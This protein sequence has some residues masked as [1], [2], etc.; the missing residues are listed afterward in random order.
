MS[1]DSRLARDVA[2]RQIAMFNSFVGRGL[3]RPLRATT[4]LA[5]DTVAD[6]FLTA[7]VARAGTTWPVVGQ[8]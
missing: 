5:P 6:V 3:S 1:A 4:V 2:D 7:S 8:P